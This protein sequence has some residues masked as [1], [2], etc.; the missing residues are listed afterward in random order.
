[1]EKKQERNDMTVANNMTIENK[2]KC[3]LDLFF[4]MNPGNKFWILEALL[5]AK[6]GEL[7][8]CNNEIEDDDHILCAVDT[9]LLAVT[10]GTDKILKE[11]AE[12]GIIAEYAVGRTTADIKALFSDIDN[13]FTEQGGKSFLTLKQ[14][15]PLDLMEI[16]RIICS[17]PSDWFQSG[18]GIFAEEVLS[19]IARNGG[20]SGGVYLQ[21]IQV[22][23]LIMDL[24]DIKDGSVYNPYAGMASYGTILNDNVEYHAQEISQ[25]YLIARLNLLLHGKDDSR[26]IQ[27]N[28]V[29]EWNE[30]SFDYIVATPPFN[31]RISE[32]RNDT[33]EAD[34]FARAYNQ[35]R[36]K[37]AAVVSGY[38][39]AATGGLAFAVRKT[40]IE[41]D[42]VEYVIKLPNNLFFETNIP[43]FVIVLNRE[44]DN[45]GNVKFVDASECFKKQGIKNVL[46]ESIVISLLNGEDSF[47]SAI[48]DNSNVFAHNCTLIPEGYI[49]RSLI[50]AKTGENYINLEHVL[51][52]CSRQNVELSNGEHPIVIFPFTDMQFSVKS[53]ELAKKNVNTHVPACLIDEDCIIIDTRKQLRSVYVTIDGTPAYYM[54][55]YHAF[56][57]DTTVITPEY[58]VM[59]LRQPYM[60]KQ[61]AFDNMVSR[62][63]SPEFYIAKVLVP[64]LE[65]QKAAVI[66]YKEQLLQD[67]GVHLNELKEK[68]LKD[69]EITQ[70]ER[71][72]AV[73][74]VLGDIYPAILDVS[75]FIQQN[76]SVSKD[77]IVTRQGDSLEEYVLK[78]VANVEKV[79]KMVQ[80]FTDT[81]KFHS[82]TTLNVEESIKAFIQKKIAKNYELVL[83]YL[84]EG[85]LIINISE[86]DLHQVF[87]NLIN[88][89]KK[90]GFT[91][92]KR[93]DYKVKITVSSSED[94]KN[95]IIHVRNNGIPVSKDFDINK[96]FAWGEGH[97]DGIGC[98]QVK[99]IIEHF[100]G[101][102][103]YAEMA[104]EADGFICDFE[105]VLPLTNDINND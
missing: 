40:L 36:K 60:A 19:F 56:K 94:E 76:N 59:Q 88:N 101:A 49:E 28:S 23:H 48:I 98:N 29:S 14:M 66:R 72:H 7:V 64:S 91:D 63:V 18:V 84:D 77:S 93:Y 45:K 4:G 35:A 2:L 32:R 44:K 102:V 97:G 50:E 53:S 99:N 47:H 85:E 38:F 68:R 55:Y 81:E 87:D 34:F 33:M 75:D 71:K 73:G 26:C 95:V 54:P 27:G 8:I 12:N 6:R 30:H 24:L 21:P 22:S 82:P 20:K 37:V 89:A 31:A 25:I 65:E 42:L 51:T 90:Y 96:I 17:L 39:C 9:S 78:I 46:D 67:M 83:E 69:F 62:G 41:K 86:E 5:L 15:E 13:T 103:N 80:H 79:T 92:K 74:H 57:V 105:I 100:G 11:W 10:A 70:R 16:V 3:I 43:A 1:M 61:I 104:N 58:L 52:P